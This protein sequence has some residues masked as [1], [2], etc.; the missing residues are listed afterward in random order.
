MYLFDFRI[1]FFEGRDDKGG[2][3]TRAVFGA[4]EDVS[5]CEGD[6]DTFF[7]DGGGVFVA[8]FEDAHEEF[9][10]EVEGFPFNAFCS[11]DVLHK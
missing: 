3:F 7:L 1:G 11:R 4:G 9:A 10:F 6:G 2:C 8:G 5:A